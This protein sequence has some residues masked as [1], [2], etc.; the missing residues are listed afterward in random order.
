MTTQQK[1]KKNEITVLWFENDRPQEELQ[2]LQTKT[3]I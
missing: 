1:K 2:G 3:S